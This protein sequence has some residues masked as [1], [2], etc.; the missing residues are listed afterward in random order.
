MANSER[1]TA[2]EARQ[3]WEGAVTSFSAVP[4]PVAKAVDDYLLMERKARAWDVLEG[5]RALDPGVGRLLDAAMGALEN[6]HGR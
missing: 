2:T 5:Q 1:M 6:A 3:G 4:D